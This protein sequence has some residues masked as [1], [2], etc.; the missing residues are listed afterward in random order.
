MAILSSVIQVAT[1]LLAVDHSDLFHR[2]AVR[3]KPIRDNRSWRSISF[4]RFLQKPK[5][6]GLIACFGHEAFQHFSF[7]VDSSPEIVLD[8]VDFHEDLIEMP[9]PLSVLAHVGGALR[10]DLAGE[11]RTKSINPKPNTLMADIDP[12]FMEQ[13]F[14]VSK[15]EREADIHHHRKLDDLGRCLEISEWI[16]AHRNRLDRFKPIGQGGLR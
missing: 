12:A 3:A 1:D 4:H 16:L 5:R 14:D 13:V 7:M 11:N 8:T 6:S 2:G 9:L 10:S 15:R